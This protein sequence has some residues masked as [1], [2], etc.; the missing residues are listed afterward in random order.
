LSTESTA[1][2]QPRRASPWKTTE[3]KQDNIQ[4]TH[5]KPVKW[6]ETVRPREGWNAH[7]V[8][9]GMHNNDTPQAPCECTS[10]VQHIHGM[11]SGKHRVRHTCSQEQVANVNPKQRCVRELDHSAQHS[12]V[13]RNTI[14]HL[15]NTMMHVRW[16]ATTATLLQ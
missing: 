9:K 14:T 13:H 15:T 10:T 6:M 2:Q 4:P 11:K 8:A 12:H 1:A 16:A 5:A 7:G 3:R